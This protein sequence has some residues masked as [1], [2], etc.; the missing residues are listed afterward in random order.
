MS[1]RAPSQ[2]P[3]S[4]PAVG[5]GSKEHGAYEEARNRLVPFQVGVGPQLP[6][7]VGLEDEEPD[8]DLILRINRCLSQYHD[9]P[10][11]LLLAEL[12]AAI[13]SEPVT[14]TAFRRTLD[15]TWML[16]LKVSRSI[17]EMMNCSVT[18]NSVVGYVVWISGLSLLY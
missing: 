6:A 7:Q 12:R 5:C 16:S 10:D 13:G 18:W 14:W 9:F 4:D 3:L 17:P 8:V 11:D 15:Y 2:R 1:P